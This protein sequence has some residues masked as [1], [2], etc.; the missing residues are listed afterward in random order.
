MEFAGGLILARVEDGVGRVTF[1]NP[2]KRNAVT[3]EMWEG[4]AAALEQF[5]SDEAVRVVV[6]AGAG[7]K[8]FVSGADISQTG[9]G[10]VKSS[11]GELHDQMHN[12]GRRKLAGFGKPLIAEI[13]GYCLGGGLAIALQADLRIASEDA[14]FGV[15][16]ARLGNAY[17]PDIAAQLMALIGPAHTSMLLLT[18]ARISG[19]E[20]A[21]IGLVNEMAAN[22]G[23][24]VTVAKLARTIAAN[25]PLSLAAAKLTVREMSK[26]E[27]RRDR[28]A[29]DRAVAACKDSADFQEGRNAFKEK[30]NPI[31]R[32]S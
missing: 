13:R 25:A 4:L 1:N 8:A 6:M 2:A 9:G 11:T 15:P 27:S 3:L 18:G 19:A 28:A 32:G 23:L 26:D 12:V 7:D 30:R 16:T 10:Q 5:E 31:F 20:A 14:Q 17:H 29:V 21:R 24:S 22:D